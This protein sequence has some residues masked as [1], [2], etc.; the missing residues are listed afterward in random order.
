MA[1]GVEDTVDTE[2][3]GVAFLGGLEG[4]VETGGGAGG[5]ASEVPDA[6]VVGKVFAQ[7]AALGDRL[8]LEEEL[9]GGR[10]LVDLAVGDLE[11]LVGVVEAAALILLVGFR[12][13]VRRV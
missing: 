4:L 12:R 1:R 9:R 10:D 13:G 7:V 3:Q 8:L 6:G 11:I 5:G 2:L